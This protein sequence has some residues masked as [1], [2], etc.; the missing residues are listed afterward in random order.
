MEQFNCRRTRIGDGIWF[1]SVVD[2]RYKTNRISVSLILPLERETA[3]VNALIPSVL[4]KGT[5]TAP[6]LLNFPKSSP[7]FMECG[8]VME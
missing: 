8:S 1:N 6:I 7:C 2:G 5:K 4:R 3:S